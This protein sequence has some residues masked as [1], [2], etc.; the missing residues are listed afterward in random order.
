M[1]E[2]KNMVRIIPLVDIKV[3]KETLSRI[4]IADKKR[5]ILYPSC[6]LW[7]N[8][9]D[10]YILHFKELFLI[11][12]TNGYNNISIE[13]LERKNSI[14]YCLITWG[15]IEVENID[16]IEPHNKYVFVLP[17]KEKNEWT[18]TQK[19]NVNGMEIVK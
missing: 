6:L 2:I 4:G 16:M 3:I 10:Y 19:F 9:E 1:A 17:F 14:I 13:D 7:Q 8:F 12:R 18:I 15:L 11:S 5:K